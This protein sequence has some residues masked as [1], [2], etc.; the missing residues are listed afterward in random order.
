MC[1]L[2]LATMRAV[3]NARN[4]PSISVAT[5]KRDSV[6]P[7]PRGK[8][9]EA[10][11]WNPREAPRSSPSLPPELERSRSLR[12]VP[13]LVGLLLVA[14]QNRRGLKEKAALATQV[15][16]LALMA[17][18]AVQ[19]QDPTQLTRSESTIRLPEARASRLSRKARPV[20]RQ[21]HWT[22]PRSGALRRLV[23]RSPEVALFSD[24]FCSVCCSHGRASHVYASKACLFSLSLYGCRVDVRC[25]RV[26]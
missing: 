25:W 15:L 4:A 21:C 20:N 5:A 9:P 3:E 16:D 24:V 8:T 26:L 11:V 23:A 2:W 6:T 18:P 7:L 13:L 14:P 17:T 12:K 10:L 19:H 1:V 22:P